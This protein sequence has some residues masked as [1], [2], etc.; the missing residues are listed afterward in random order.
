MKNEWLVLKQDFIQDLVFKPGKQGRGAIYLTNY[1]PH[2]ISVYGYFDLKTCRGG[3]GWRGERYP[4]E[5]SGSI[6]FLR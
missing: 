2:M 3:G 1:I 6:P 5:G 4:S